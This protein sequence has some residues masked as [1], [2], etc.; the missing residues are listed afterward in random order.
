MQD[1][2]FTIAILKNLQRWDQEIAIDDFG[3]GYSSLAYLKRFPLQNLDR[4]VIYPGFKSQGRARRSVSAIIA[5]SRNLGLKVLAEGV[6]TNSNS[7]I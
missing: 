4:S 6:E 7:I 3:T 1:P 2:D 5:M